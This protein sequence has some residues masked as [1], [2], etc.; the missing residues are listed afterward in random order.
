MSDVTVGLIGVAAGA[1]ATG[2]VRGFGRWLDLRHR[3]RTAARLL[4]GDLHEARVILT[5]AVRDGAWKGR[6]DF[7]YA[8]ATW[9]EYRLD[10]AGATSVRHFI[11]LLGL[12]RSSIDSKTC[13]RGDR[14]AMRATPCS[15]LADSKR[16]LAGWTWLD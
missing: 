2:G 6:R 5:E 3:R 1:L 10:V 9:S 13:V 7:A 12:L 16:R 14:R 11:A 8:M 4:F 15:Y